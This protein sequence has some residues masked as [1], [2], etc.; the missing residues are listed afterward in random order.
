VLINST[1][2]FAGQS[3]SYGVDNV[4]GKKEDSEEDSSSRSRID[5][6]S[7][8]LKISSYFFWELRTSK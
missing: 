5:A 1:E 8:R 3:E 6:F 7:F 2:A 4:S